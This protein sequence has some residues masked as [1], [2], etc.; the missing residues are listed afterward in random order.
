MTEQKFGRITD[1]LSWLA[2]AFE[3]ARERGETRLPWL[4]SRKT[5][6]NTYARYG[7]LFRLWSSS[8]F[9]PAE[10]LTA[11]PWMPLGYKPEP[12]TMVATRLSN[13]IVFHAPGDMVS[14]PKK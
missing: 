8:R 11:R 1:A 10:L 7:E 14:E 12:P 13:A 6:Q 5:Q 4:P 3:M 2:D 9:V